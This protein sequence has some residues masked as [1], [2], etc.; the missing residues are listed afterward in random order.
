M[1]RGNQHLTGAA[2]AASVE[3]YREAGRKAWLKR[4]EA[5]EAV[6]C[7][8]APEHMPLWDRIGGELK[9]PPAAR[10]SAFEHYMHDHPSEVIEAMCEAAEAK[11]SAELEKRAQDDAAAS[12]VPF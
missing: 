12:E 2:K 5:E 4:L 7:N 1:A 8:I 11:L 9:G 10:L 6:T 3:R